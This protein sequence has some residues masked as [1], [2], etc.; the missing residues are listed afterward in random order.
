MIELKGTGREMA[1]LCYHGNGM[2]TSCQRQQTAYYFQH[3]RQLHR[4]VNAVHSTVAQAC[5]R[6]PSN[7]SFAWR[8]K[9]LI[10]DEQCPTKIRT[11]ASHQQSGHALAIT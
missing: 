10:G 2:N 6:Q 9:E 11:T 4:N 1:D 7:F 3:S 5:P 8:P